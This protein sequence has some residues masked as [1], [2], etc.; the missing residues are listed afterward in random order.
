MSQYCCKDQDE[1]SVVLRR[2]GARL[3]VDMGTEGQQSLGNAKERP[4]TTQ[5]TNGAHL[6]SLQ[7]LLVTAPELRLRNTRT[8]WL[9]PFPTVQ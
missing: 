3:H 7:D 9:H 2:S 1:K 6:E 4:G 5:P 8:G